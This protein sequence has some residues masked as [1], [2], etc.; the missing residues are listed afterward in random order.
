MMKSLQGIMA[1]KKSRW[2]SIT[3]ID[4]TILSGFDKLHEHGLPTGGGFAFVV[5]KT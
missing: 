4:R 2:L 5:V 1:E 3:G